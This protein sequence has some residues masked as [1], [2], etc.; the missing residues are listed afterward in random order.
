MNSRLKIERIKKTLWELRE[1]ETCCELCPRE[2]KVNRKKGEKGFCQMGREPFLS[3]ALLHYGEEPVLSGYGD[4]NQEKSN[5]SHR[6]GSGAL[7]FTGCHL[8]CPF[9][10]NYQLSWLNQG[11]QVTSQQ[12]AEHM[13]SLQQKGA[14]NINLVS[15]THFL[16]PILEALKQAY[17]E[18]FTIP[19]V[20][21]SNGYEKTEVVQKLDGIVDIYLPDLKYHSSSLSQKLSGVPD[22]F[23]KASQAILEMHRQQPQ[24]VVDDN[25]AAQR[26]L[27]IRHLILPGMSSDSLKLLEWINSHL[28]SSVCLSLMSQYHPC[29]KAPPE[30][31]KCLSPQEFHKVLAQAKKMDLDTLFYQPEPF[32]LQ[33]HLVPDFSLPDPFGFGK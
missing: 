33:E 15:P 17:K 29:F 18:G 28:D 31:Q 22:Y 11:K 1:H 6:N 7:F 20:Y 12:L 30:L 10:Q 14:L 3:H 25:N 5:G 32:S 24:L 19:V 9:C 16:I 23:P 4:W 26:G 8:K 2:C 21:N 27:I 13:L